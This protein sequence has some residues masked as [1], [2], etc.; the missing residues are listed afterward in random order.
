MKQTITAL[1]TC[2]TSPV[3]RGKCSVLASAFSLLQAV[4]RRRLRDW[5]SEGDI[6]LQNHE[7]TVRYEKT[8]F[9]HEIYYFSTS[10]IVSCLFPW[11]IRRG[12]RYT[13][14]LQLYIYI[15]IPLKVHI[16]GWHNSLEK[17]RL[18]G[19]DSRKQFDS[20]SAWTNR[21]ALYVPKP[22]APFAAF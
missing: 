7:E 16:C 4:T 14:T 8:S 2:P 12:P 19:H 22:I 6:D 15:Y 5:G 11:T 13:S 17:S 9:Y 1:V 10:F 21:C 20:I 3:M 18:F